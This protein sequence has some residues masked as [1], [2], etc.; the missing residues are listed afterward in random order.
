MMIP[1]CADDIIAHARECYPLE[2]CGLLVMVGRR[3]EYFPCANVSGARDT[4]VID[5]EDYLLAESSG[6]IIAVVHSHP[7]AAA[8][9]SQADR[10]SCEASGLPWW[11]L[12]INQEDTPHWAHIEPSGYQAPLVGRT[13]SHGVLDCYSII[14]DW[15]RMERGVTLPDF[16]RNVEWWYKGENI[17]V[18]NFEKAG[19]VRVD[20]KPQH[21]DVLL[22][23]V[24]AN[25]PNHGA[26]YLDG[27]I[28][29]HHLHNRLSCR[30]VYGG[31]YRK[32]TTHVLRYKG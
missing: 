4:F 29:L 27:D 25:V 3:A 6:E 7:D 26:I 15:Y 17:Y 11:V 32:H 13:W 16:H 23:Q 10:V 9:P 8:T 18:E 31:Y 30:E 20:D 24:L 2:C 12:G 28:I 1:P 22:M 19:F 5:P 21:G 14:R